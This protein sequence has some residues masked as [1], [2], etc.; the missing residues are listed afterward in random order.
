MQPSRWA[1]ALRKGQ[2]DVTV[3]WIKEGEGGDARGDHAASL[4]LN[5]FTNLPFAFLV[6]WCCT[7]CLRRAC[8]VDSTGS[9]ESHR[10]VMLPACPELQAYPRYYLDQGVLNVFA[11]VVS[12]DWRLG[13]RGVGGGGRVCM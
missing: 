13:E 10:D 7:V 8:T 5:W 12:V 1:I 9:H 11:F 3:R 6:G 4:C 2:E